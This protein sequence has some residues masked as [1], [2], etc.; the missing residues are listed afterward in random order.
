MERVQVIDFHR[1]CRRLTG[2]TCRN[3]QQYRG[4]FGVNDGYLYLL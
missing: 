1:L 4:V 2:D 3:V